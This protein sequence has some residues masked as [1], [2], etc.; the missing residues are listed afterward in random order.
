MAT[1]T[2]LLTCMILPLSPV[3]VSILSAHLYRAGRRLWHPRVR[4]VA[5]SIFL[6]G[7]C[8]GRRVRTKIHGYT[9]IS[10][11]TKP[12]RL[13]EQYSSSFGF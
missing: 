13:T 9:T 4:G 10:Y 3:A 2:L 6:A 8:T 1:G 12:P 7:S 5:G 11:S